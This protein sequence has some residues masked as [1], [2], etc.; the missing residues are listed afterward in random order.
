[1]MSCVKGQFLRF[2]LNRLLG[3]CVGSSELLTLR[4]P[5]GNHGLF[6]LTTPV[7]NMLRVTSIV[8]L[9]EQ[10]QAVPRGTEGHQKERKVHLL[11][12]NDVHRMRAQ[13]LRST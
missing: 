9:T 10:P 8:S 11:P 12:I 1:M 13:V 5:A 7:K 4:K 6:T 2:V 3:N